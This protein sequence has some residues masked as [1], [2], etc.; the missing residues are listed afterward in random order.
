MKRH[1]AGLLFLIAAVPGL[2]AGGDLEKA[3]ELR[4][5]VI[6]VLIFISIFIIDSYGEENLDPNIFPCGFSPQIR[7]VYNFGLQG[8]KIGI[9]QDT[10]S[11]LEEAHKETLN[12]S[13]KENLLQIKRDGIC[14]SVFKGGRCLFSQLY[15][16]TS[17]M[18]NSEAVCFLAARSNKTPFGIHRID[19]GALIDDYEQ[20]KLYVHQMETTQEIFL[21]KNFYPSQLFLSSKGMHIFIKGIIVKTT[22]DGIFSQII[23]DNA[24]LFY[25][26][27]PKRLYP[28]FIFTSVDASVSAKVLDFS[29][30]K[31][32][33]ILF[34]SNNGTGRNQVLF[35]IIIDKEKYISP[36][37]LDL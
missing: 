18:S 23:S 14:Y 24:Y 10:I 27:K 15:N 28:V 35:E 12:K 19:Y 5:T 25:D 8:E 22:K 3:V 1:I 4:K 30:N 34:E 33:F 21:P 7:A 17:F 36:T 11:L 13:F 32:A 2:F 9:P 31:I 29:T 37:V 20:L 26:I 16:V 6:I